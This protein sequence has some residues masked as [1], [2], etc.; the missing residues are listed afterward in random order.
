MKVGFVTVDWSGIESQ[1]EKRQQP[2]GAGWYRIVL[3]YKFLKLN[4]VDVVLG[5][6]IL[7]TLAGEFHV[8]TFDDA[9]HKDFDIIV[10][11]RWMSE[12][13]AD[14]IRHAR[15]TGQVIIQDIDDHFDAIDP[16]NR[17]FYTTHPRKDSTMHRNHYK[18]AIQAS[19]AIWTSTPYLAKHYEGT[20]LPVTVLENCIDRS[21]F[22][23]R[24]VSGPMEVG[25]TGATGFRSGDLSI[26]AGHL[27]RFLSTHNP[28]F[29]HTGH[30]DHAIEAGDLLALGPNIERTYS[31]LVGIE[32]YPVTFGAFN[33][34]IVPLAMKAFN[35]AKSYIKGLE[36]ATSGI[37]FVASPT[38]E[39][40]RFVRELGAG[41]TASRPRDWIRELGK[42]SDE[43]Y[44]V[45]QGELA[46][47][48]SV[49][50]DMAT[51][52]VEWRKALE[53]NQEVT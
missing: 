34:G 3:P 30:T 44:R 52:W 39:Y 17:A 10:M 29:H 4:G 46:R 20:G 31:P 16:G 9:I 5:H 11:Q 32:Q 50:W 49:R 33:V 14:C 42:L 2:G 21:Q 43:Q 37:P 1:E 24:D 25:W 48:G 35:E 12:V 13:A 47:A 19:S 38:R 27:G 6:D 36:Y 45:E 18:R 8:R 22:P 7:Q 51:R 53:E 26:L 41:A 28:T 40:I 23:Q 15:S